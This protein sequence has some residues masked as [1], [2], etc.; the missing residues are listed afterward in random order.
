MLSGYKTY[1]TGAVAIVGIVAGVLTGDMTWQAAIPGV[2]TAVMGMTIRH[3]I[4]TEA[5]K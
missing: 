2:I 3:G 1:I 5:S 4:T